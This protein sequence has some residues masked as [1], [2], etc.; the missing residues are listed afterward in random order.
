MGFKYF[1]SEQIRWWCR[2]THGVL[3]GIGPWCA[4]CGCTGLQQIV[5]LIW[6]A[7]VTLELS[8]TCDSF[9][10]AWS[11]SSVMFQAAGTCV[12]GKNMN[13]G[14]GLPMLRYAVYTNASAIA[15]S[16]PRSC[17]EHFCAGTKERE[18]NGLN[19][20]TET[21]QISCKR[22][23][24]NILKVNMSQFFWFLISLYQ[25]SLQIA[26]IVDE[27]VYVIQGR[28]ADLIILQNFEVSNV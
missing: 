28:L 1:E 25:M 18:R 5:V 6:K 11:V 9:I 19:I 24:A 2:D 26:A 13:I 20:D 21:N 4:G 14:S 8:D 17:L 3:F 22:H 7:R 23:W 16:M 27:Q 15:A 12:Q 10:L